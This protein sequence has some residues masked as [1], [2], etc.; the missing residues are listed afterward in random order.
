MNLG[1]LWADV[2]TASGITTEALRTIRTGSGGMRPLTKRGIEIA[3]LWEQ[4]SV[5]AILN[6]GDPT[7]LPA[8]HS[9]DSRP[10]EPAVVSAGVSTPAPWIATALVTE[11]VSTEDFRPIIEVLRE[12]GRRSGY[13]LGETL[14]EAGLAAA[15]ELAVRRSAPSPGHTS[16]ERHEAQVK[17][18]MDNPDFSGG[19]KADMVASLKK[20]REALNLA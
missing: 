3:L 5:D 11:G 12:L 14:V 19:E 1:L 15:S 6:G 18:I 4:G 10:A 16:V 17:W 8:G 2:A 20:L 9:Q 13:T 7:P